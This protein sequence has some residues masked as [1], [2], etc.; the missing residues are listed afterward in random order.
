[1]WFHG[2]MAQ[3]NL[4][5][6]DGALA[7]VIDFGTCGVGDPA[8]DVAIAWTLLTGTSRAAFRN[9]LAMDEETWARGR[10]WALWKTLDA[11]VE[12]LEEGVL[13]AEARVLDQIFE[14]FERS[15]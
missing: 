13:A 7:A 6:K 5:M 1:V 2:D 3:T 4:L 11:Y 10:G 9:G 12:A 8:C 14:K 15:G